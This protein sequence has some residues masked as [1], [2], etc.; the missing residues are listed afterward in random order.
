MVDQ[1]WAK[2]QYSWNWCSGIETAS[3]ICKSRVSFKGAKANCIHVHNYKQKDEWMNRET[4]KSWFQKHF[5]SEVWACLKEGGLPQKALLL[6]DNAHFHPRDSVLT[7]AD[8][9][10]VVIEFLPPIVTVLY[11]PW[12]KK[13]LC[14]WNNATELTSSKLLPMKTL[15]SIME[16]NYSAG[17][18]I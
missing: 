16:K 10:T 13:L 12:A 8:S 1:I 17:C 9:I 7:S 3:V 6:L 14:P 5:V 4:S 18:Y 11:N 15:K 2:I